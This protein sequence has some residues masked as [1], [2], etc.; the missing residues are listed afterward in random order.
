[1]EE[2]KAW[3]EWVAKGFEAQERA[4]ERQCFPNLCGDFDDDE[5]DDDSDV[6]VATKANAT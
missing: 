5:S 2:Q 1:M 4:E 3:D 6:D